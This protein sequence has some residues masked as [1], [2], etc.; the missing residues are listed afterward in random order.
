MGHIGTIAIIFIVTIFKIELLKWNGEWSFQGSNFGKIVGA[1]LADVPQATP[2]GQM[3]I[4]L[5]KTHEDS[6]V[7]LI[8][9]FRPKQ[10]TNLTARVV[11]ISFGPN[12]PWPK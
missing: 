11:N 12:S 4:F 6:Q 2:I 1:P 9:Q 3:V 10:I 5:I 7:F 8:N